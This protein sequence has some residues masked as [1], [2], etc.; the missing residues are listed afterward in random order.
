MATRSSPRPTDTTRTRSP[1]N[2]RTHYRSGSQRRSKSS[3]S[4]RRTHSR[5]R[6]RHRSHLQYNSHRSSS[7]NYRSSRRRIDFQSNDYDD[8]NYEDYDMDHYDEF[9]RYGSDHGQMHL[10]HLSYDSVSPSHHSPSVRDSTD[11]LATEQEGQTG[12]R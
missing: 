7:R 3:P 11:L 10:S 12:E 8:Y 6:S 4:N 9:D 5:S 2:R 1:S